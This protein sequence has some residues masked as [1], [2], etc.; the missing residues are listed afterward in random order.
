MENGIVRETAVEEDEVSFVRV[1]NVL[2]RHRR[3]IIGIPIVLV[4]LIVVASMTTPRS[5]SATTVFMPQNI[6]RSPTS[7][8]GALARQMGVNVGGESGAQSPRFYARLLESRALLRQ[9]AMTEYDLPMDDGSVRKGSLIETFDL[10]EANERERQHRAIERLRDRLTVTVDQETGIVSVRVAASTPALAEQIANRLLELINEYNLGMRRSRALAERDFVTSQLEDAQFEL[11]R[12]ETALQDFL[13]QNRM[14]TNSPELAFEHGRLSRVVQMRQDIVTSLMQSR[15]Q[16]G[17]DA[18]RETPAISVI[19][20]AAGS[21]MPNA[22]GTVGRA[23]LAGVAGGAAAILLAFLL[24]FARRTRMDEREAYREFSAL[25]RAAWQDV[26]RPL[27]LLRRN[28][29]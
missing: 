18:V 2:L 14:F 22:R 6:E 7:A 25:K 24:E 29:A 16:A 21:A 15:E 5:Y 9:A 23:I 20:P 3:L 1:V 11:N 13:R 12:A 10:Q 28:R 27:A 26:K 17:I 4:A 8:V 19:E